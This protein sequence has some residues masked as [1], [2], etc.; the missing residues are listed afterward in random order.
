MIADP[1]LRTAFNEAK[2]ALRLTPAEQKAAE[3]FFVKGYVAG[4]EMC[5]AQ[6]RKS[7]ARDANKA[8]KHD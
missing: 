1:K 5:T 2:G 4:V 3:L 8:D 6:L 7:N